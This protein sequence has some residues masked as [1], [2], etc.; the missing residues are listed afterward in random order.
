MTHVRYIKILTWLRGLRV[1]IANF[2]RLHCLAI[3]KR[4]LNTKNTK[5]NIAKWP[6]SLGVADGKNCSFPFSETVFY[7]LMTMDLTMQ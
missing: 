2:L 4:D 3:P 1:K 7:D 5:P 6:E